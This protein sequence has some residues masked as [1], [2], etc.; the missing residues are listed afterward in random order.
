M[1]QTAETVVAQRVDTAQQPS[2]EAAFPS[3]VFNVQK[4]MVH[5]RVFFATATV[6]SSEEVINLS[7]GA[8]IFCCL[9]IVLPTGKVDGSVTEK[10]VGVPFAV[11]YWG[12]IAFIKFLFNGSTCIVVTVAV[13]AVVNSADNSHGDSLSL[14]V[15]VGMPNANE[16]GDL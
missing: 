4:V 16:F 11:K 13:I 10:A 8:D 7:T 3:I 14:S 9:D 15:C 2:T 12:W 6:V 5:V 1:A